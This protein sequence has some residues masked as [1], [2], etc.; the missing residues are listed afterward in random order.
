MAAVEPPV[1]EL[2][3]Q[4]EHAAAPV[5]SLKWSAE[6]AVGVPPSAPVYPAFA[7]HAVAVVEPVTPPVAELAGQ[8]THAEEEAA[9]ALYLPIS[10]A[11][12]LLPLPVKPAAATQAV[13]AVEPTG[14][15]VD[16]GHLY[17][18]SSALPRHSGRHVF[19]L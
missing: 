14:Q 4:S 13:A 7:T 5:A 17:C 19:V 12:T 18:F 8:P 9:A 10:H 1:A 16:A 6:Q 3:G 11:E 2:S 15:D